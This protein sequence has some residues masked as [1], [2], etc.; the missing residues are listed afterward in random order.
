MKNLPVT[1]CLSALSVF[2]QNAPPANADAELM[3]NRCGA[4]S[5]LGDITAQPSWNGWGNGVSNTRYQGAAAQLDSSQIPKLTLKWAF[6]FPGAKAAW[7][8]PTVV[9]G[10]VFLGV[11][12]GYVYSINAST[13]CVYWSFLA[14]GP[15]RAAI[16]VGPAKTGGQYLAYVGDLKGNVYA[17]NASTGE[18]VWKVAMDAHPQARITGAPQ[19]YEGRLYVPV[20]SFEEVAAANPTYECCTFRGSVA[21]LDAMTG[22]QIWKTYIIPEAP[23]A[24]G[25]NSKGVQQHG[26]AGGGVWNSPTL[27]PKRRA[28][29]VGT[30]DSYTAPAAKTTD[31]IAALDM[32]NG[33]MLWSF[34]DTPGD[35]WVVGCPQ[36][37]TFL[38]TVLR[39]LVPTMISAP[40]PF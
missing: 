13:G 30:G 28:L 12:T 2:A 25:K 8:Q 24:R 31:A 33:R 32:D 16:S 10:R 9:A 35:A 6:G 36:R 4:N 26:P 22:R 3:Q 29:Y 34:Q 5:P 7:G 38:P 37:T 20:A 19:L 1:L 14:A 21:A 17:L 40:R 27:D 15:V 18:Q 23:K 39:T 11:D